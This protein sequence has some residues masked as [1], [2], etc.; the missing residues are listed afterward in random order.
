MNEVEAIKGMIDLFEGCEPFS[1]DNP[2]Y[3]SVKFVPEYPLL[4]M[5]IPLIALS[6]S[7]G[8]QSRTRGVGSYLRKAKPRLQL[9]VLA[10]TGIEALRIFQHV[11]R[12][13]I[14]DYEN[15][16]DSDGLGLGYLRSLGVRWVALGEPMP[17]TWDEQGRVKR[18]TTQLQYE[19]LQEA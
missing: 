1:G 3:S 15:A 12:V 11:R 6:V 9:D 16:D 10:S 19:Y 2:L 5:D 8:P 17:A 4:T 13:L 18:L 14:A 7:G